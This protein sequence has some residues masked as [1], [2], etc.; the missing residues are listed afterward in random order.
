MD[1]LDLKDVEAFL[2]VV[3]SGSFTA[4]ARE[5]GVNQSV[6]S[7]RVAHLEEQLDVRI[8]ER[9]A[10]RSVPTPA[11]KAILHR[12]RALLA[13][14]SELV[15]EARRQ[16]ET[17]AGE[18]RIA[19]ST[20]P[21][22]FYLPALLADLRRHAP[23]VVPDLRVTNTK[24][25]LDALRDLEVE[26]A[27]VGRVPDEP[28][29]RVETIWS[30]AVILVSSRMIAAGLADQDTLAEVPL[31]LRQPGSATRDA[32]L[33]SIPERGEDGLRVVMRVPDGE[34][35]REAALAGIGATFVSERA[36]ARDLAAGSLVR[37]DHVFRP[38]HRP[39][40]LVTRDD[41]PQ[42]AAASLLCDLLRAQARGAELPAG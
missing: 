36:V 5:L 13:Q 27:V 30:D 20:V 1:R 26:L 40:A 9:G 35:A 4:A 18:L 10:R 15:L 19:S 6:I 7:T 2:R 41:A 3:D 29:L 32:V 23:G 12:A 31:V 8:V 34:V 21:G 11:G 22:A 16:A 42:T 24:R 17:P 33:A 39:I 37:L 14:A 38:I 28:G 25:A